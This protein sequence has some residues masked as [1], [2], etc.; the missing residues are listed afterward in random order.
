MIG[1]LVTLYQKLIIFSNTHQVLMW[2]THA[3]YSFQTLRPNAPFLNCPVL[4]FQLN[5]RISLEQPKTRRVDEHEH[6]A[7]KERRWV[8]EG[9]KK[10]LF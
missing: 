7:I 8:T 5:G 10:R 6:A 4:S 3:W 2:R 1:P 9:G